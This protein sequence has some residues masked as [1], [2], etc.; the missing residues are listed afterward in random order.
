M[1][2]QMSKHYETIIHYS[3]VHNTANVRSAANEI[4]YMLRNNHATSSHY[5][6]DDQGIIQV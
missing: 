3:T 6:V 4:S 1:Q 5:A 2:H